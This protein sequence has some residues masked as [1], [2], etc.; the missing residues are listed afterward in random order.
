LGGVVGFGNFV[1]LRRRFFIG[2]LNVQINTQAPEYSAGFAV[3]STVDLM[4]MTALLGWTLVAASI[5]AGLYYCA[6]GIAALKHLSKA[7]EQ[8]RF[9]GWTLWWFLEA[10]RYDEQGKSLCR[11]GATVFT[12]AWGLAV[13][14][15]YFALRS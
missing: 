5:M 6:L 14:G 15:Y 4:G 7:T 13:P 3:L 1:D 2:A 10:A 8:D 11:L 9:V 12:V